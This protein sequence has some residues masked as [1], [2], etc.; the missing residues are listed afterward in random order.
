MV[1]RVADDKTEQRLADLEAR[2]AALEGRDRPVPP[3]TEA[4]PG[5]TGDTFF[6]VNELR[7]RVQGLGGV[8]YAGTVRR[9]E[10][11]EPL[12]WQ[13][14][15][16]LERLDESDWSRL[17]PR[18]DALGNSVRLN[19]LHEIWNGAST[20]A[21]L[22]ERPGFGTTGQ[23]YHHV[24]QLTSAG[25]LAPTRRGHYSIPPERVVPLLVILAAAGDSP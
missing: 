20:V 16:P 15:H 18:I 23:I 7:R 1:E 9:S 3:R 21:E 6:A 4:A 11:E 17:A 19:L 5:S 10:H 22:A 25:W 2:V 24:N 14:G 13:Y 12:E 8:L